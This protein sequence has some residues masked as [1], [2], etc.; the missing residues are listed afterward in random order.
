MRFRCGGIRRV[1][2][3]RCGRRVGGGA[4]RR[5]SKSR[6]RFSAARVPL[7]F[8]RNASMRALYGEQAD[9]PA[10]ENRTP[11]GLPAVQAVCV[12]ST[13]KDGRPLAV[14]DG[15]E[16]TYWRT[17]ADSAL[18]ARVLA[19][20]SPRCSPGGR[21]RRDVD[22]GWCMASAVRHRWRGFIWNRTHARAVET[23][24]SL[25]AQS[26]DAVAVEDLD[27]AVVAADIITTC[28]RSREPLIKEHC[29][30]PGHISIWLA[31]ITANP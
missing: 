9:H 8:V 18:G 17:A 27:A 4:P 25:R 30:A 28:T 29:C 3:F 1:L 5:R 6:M 19:R 24:A 15:T 11:G 26:I 31:A 21:R 14:L 12:I 13:G 23:A 10:P 16:L 7:Y 2:S 22:Q 20:L